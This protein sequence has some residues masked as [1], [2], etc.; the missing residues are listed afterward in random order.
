M[1]R[2]LALL[3]VLLVLV[4]PTIAGAHEYTFGPLRIVH[5]WAR[6]TPPGAPNG[7]AYL[8]IEN[9]GAEADRLVGVAT[10][11]A[12]RAEL[13]ETRREGE[14]MTM[15]PL[16]AVTIEP[17]QTVSFAPG[18]MHI[19]ML[20]LDAPLT[21]GERFPMTLRFERAGELAVEVVV[22]RAGPAPGDD[23]SGHM[24]H[25]GGGGDNDDDDDDH[26][27]G[28]HGDDRHHGAE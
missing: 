10:L 24:E 11:R 7:A 20:G 2:A 22:E 19:M 12:E 15:R 18:G 28:R 13:H 21:E 27:D 9:A 25:D 3:A 17:G 16:D 1:T 14:L 6:F 4:G 5:P 26:G 23:H 8:T